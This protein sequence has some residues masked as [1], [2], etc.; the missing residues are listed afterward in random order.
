MEN[1]QTIQEMHTVPTVARF[2]NLCRRKIDYAVASGDV[3]VVRYGKAV[4]IAHDELIR[5]MNEG[6]PAHKQ[7]VSNA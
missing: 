7:E 5:L 4:R 2:L 3:R 6:L 1:P